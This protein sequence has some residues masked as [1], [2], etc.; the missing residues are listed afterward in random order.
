MADGN[1]HPPNRRFTAA[2]VWYDCYTIDTH[3]F[4]L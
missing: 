2:D 4:V 3:G 1:P